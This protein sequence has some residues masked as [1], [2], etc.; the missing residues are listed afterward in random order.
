ME[1]KLN[2]NED[3]DV[4]E[5][6]N[7]DLLQP[8]I[9][10]ERANPPKRKILNFISYILL[11]A[12]VAFIVLGFIAMGEDRSLALI[13]ILSSIIIIACAVLGI[14]FI[15]N[16][17]KR[18][19]DNEGRPTVKLNEDKTITFYLADKT[20]KMVE[21]SDIVSAKFTPRVVVTYQVIYITYTPQKDGTL[22]VKLKDGQTL[23]VHNVDECMLV[24]NKINL[25]I[26]VASK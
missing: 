19:K 17:E 23:K 15:K 24:A 3:L 18:K 16:A 10:G 22:I 6:A 21:I 8:G 26:S 5:T 2:N 1:Q 7:P 12:G 20:E 14:V 4:S 11:F 25:L 9:I 13:I